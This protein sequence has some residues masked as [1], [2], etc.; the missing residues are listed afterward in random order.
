MTKGSFSLT[1][2]HDDNNNTK[3]IE[4]SKI[5]IIS[6]PKIIENITSQKM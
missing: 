3:E 6:R 1:S 2:E 5:L 4:Q